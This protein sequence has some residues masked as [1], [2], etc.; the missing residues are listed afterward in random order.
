MSE[1]RLFFL[2]NT[3]SQFEL[4]FA[5]DFSN[6]VIMNPNYNENITVY[7]DGYEFVACFSFQHR[8]FEDQNNLT[9]WIGEIISGNTFAIEFFN[10]EQRSFGGEI[11]KDEL[12]GLSYEKLGQLTGY[13]TKLP[14]VADGF[15]IRGWDRKNNFDYTMTCEANRS[16]TLSKV[17]VELP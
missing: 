4:Q 15:K 3:F 7:D 9:K 11:K 5:D 1:N 2:K 14:D 16:I 13:A 12:R 8:H 17:F 6:V 10:H